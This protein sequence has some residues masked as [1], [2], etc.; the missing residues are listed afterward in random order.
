MSATHYPEHTCAACHSR[1]AWTGRE[2]LMAD[3]TGR[4]RTTQPRKPEQQAEPV[5][6]RCPACHAPLAAPVGSVR[7]VS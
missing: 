2:W 4:T 3:E 1:F 7:E 6:T 5:I